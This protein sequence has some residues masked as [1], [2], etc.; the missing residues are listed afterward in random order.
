MSSRTVTRAVMPASRPFV[1]AQVAGVIEPER[2]E[3]DIVRRDLGE[4]G[5]SQDRFGHVLDRTLH[6]LVDERDVA[7]FPE[8][9]REMTSCRV[10]SGSTIASRPRR[11]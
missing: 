1:L 11:P 4:G 8:T 10:I 2:L 6:D 7:V 3:I 5:L 9:T